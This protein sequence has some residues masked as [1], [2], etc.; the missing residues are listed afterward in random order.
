MDHILYQIF[1]AIFSIFKKYIYKE[2]IDNPPIRI[3]VNKFEKRIEFKIK[4]GCNLE[5]LT[6]ETMKLLGSNGSV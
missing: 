5:L 3:Y 6:P 4:A 2:E 1:K